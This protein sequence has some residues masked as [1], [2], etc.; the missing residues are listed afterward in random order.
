VPFSVASNY[1][2]VSKVAH[3]PQYRLTGRVPVS[4]ERIA[5]PPDDRE[6]GVERLQAQ[7]QFSNVHIYA[8]TTGVCAHATVGLIRFV[9]TATGRKMNPKVHSVLSSVSRLYREVDRV[10]LSA[11]RTSRCACMR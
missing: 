9:Y 2:V 7:H 1:G 4:A 8:T 11:S 6:R 5:S 10:E 3:A